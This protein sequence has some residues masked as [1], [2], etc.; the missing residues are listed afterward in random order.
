MRAL[1]IDLLPS[2]AVD[3]ERVLGVPTDWLRDGR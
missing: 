2:D 1:I 3:L